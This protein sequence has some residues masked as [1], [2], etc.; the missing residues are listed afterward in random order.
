[1]QIQFSHIV[2]T[3][4]LFFTIWSPATAADFL[5]PSPYRA[6][7]LPAAG[8][9]VSPFRQLAFNYFY[10]E[11][12]ED[13]Q[14]NTPGVSLREFATANISIATS[15]SVDGDDGVIDGLSTGTRRSLFSNFATSSYTFDFSKNALGGVLPTHAGIVWTDIGR[16]FGGDPLAADLVD[17][18][19]FEAFGPTGVS[20]GVIGLF[21]LGD[22][23]IN[24]T[25]PE[26]RFLGVISLDG[27]SAIRIS[28]PGKN[29]WEVD[30][31]QYGSVASVPEPAGGA[32][33][34]LG[35]VVLA[36]RRR[37]RR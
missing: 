16:N 19:L 1:M 30:H 37:H 11:D 14:L 23:V 10:L 22:S 27:I 28:M 17:N 15:D 9:A 13:G 29:N 12:F 36:Y 26:D 33:L 31:L 4:L 20:L 7:D 21:S 24:R 35:G 34:C 5:G 2:C 25:T 32:L 6:F 3:V 18:T 8:T